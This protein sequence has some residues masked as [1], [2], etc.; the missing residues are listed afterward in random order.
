MASSHE[1]IIEY[2][3]S[4]LKDKR[5]D[6]RLNAINDLK[7]LGAAA[8]PALEALEA[9]HDEAEEDDVRAAAQQAGYDIFMA[10][11]N[12]QDEEPES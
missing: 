6:V 3:I 5:P 7:A 8:S 11:K 9:C 12:S 2:L 10:A 4:R 1:K